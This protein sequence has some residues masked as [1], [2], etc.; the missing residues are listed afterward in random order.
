MKNILITGGT[1]LVGTEIRN[2]LAT[3]DYITGI[4]TGRK[5]I[6][7]ENSFF[8]DYERGIIDDK[9]IEFAD[10]IIHLAGENI[11][12]KRWDEKQK[13]KILNSRTETT[14]LLYDAI[15]RV[16]KKPEKIISASAVG[17]YGAVTSEKIF[18][19]TDLPGSDFLSEVVINWE[20]SVKKFSDLNV[21]F[22]LLRFGIVIS[23]TGGALEKMQT[24]LKYFV[25]SPI[26]TGRQYMPWIEISDLAQIFLFLIE[27]NKPGETYNAVS[28]E[29][30]DNIQ[31]TQYLAEAMNR[32][33]IAPAIP[34]WF[35]RIIFGEMA[36]ILTKGSRVSSEKLHH[37]GFRFRY[38]KIHDVFEDY[39]GK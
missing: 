3:H 33:M 10:I 30:I 2:L 4:L 35:L 17:Y 36:D 38:T 32:P 27:N 6:D 16:G 14:K 12:S 7:L 18:K 19:E 24:P 5:N 15:K 37:E 28:P 34:E 13:I 22:N 25:G 11:S 9:A 1:G 26:G 21:D 20:E 8:W 23:P 39:Y 31:F 29:Y